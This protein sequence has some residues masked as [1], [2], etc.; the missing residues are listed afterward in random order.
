MATNDDNLETVV[1]LACLTESRTNAEQ[2]A[3]LTVARQV[4]DRRNTRVSG[5]HYMWAPNGRG[6]YRQ[7][8]PFSDLEG[9]ADSTRV[10]YEADEKPV[11]LKVRKRKPGEE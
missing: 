3:L 4:D 5:N 2:R 10:L 6:G 9:L 8:R 1:R 11:A 7:L